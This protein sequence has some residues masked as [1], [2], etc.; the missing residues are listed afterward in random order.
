MQNAVFQLIEAHQLF[1]KEIE[2][3]RN[4]FLK[5]KGSVDTNIYFVESGSMKV[6]VLNDDEEQIIRFAYRGNIIV[7]LD[8]YITEK[9][10]DFYIQAIKK[11]TVKV[12]SKNSMMEVIHQKPEYQ[13]L[14]IEVLEDLILQ[15]IEREKDLLTTSPKER[16]NRVL[17][18]SPMLF[19]EIPNKHISNYLRMSAETLS[20]LKKS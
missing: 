1:E 14:W 5:V 18:R 16:Y 10:S 7:S 9:P 13:K 12:I 4:E 15:Q 3:Q 19:Q 20:R 6:F 11:T 8:S 2:L 17:K